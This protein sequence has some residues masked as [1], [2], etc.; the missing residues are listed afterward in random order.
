MVHQD[1]WASSLW[2]TLYRLIETN[3]DSISISSSGFDHGLSDLLRYRS[4]NRVEMAQ[5]PEVFC[6][7]GS[8]FE[9]IFPL[10]VDWAGFESLFWV[11]LM[12]VRDVG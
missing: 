8:H 10:D 9:N 3:G 12:V 4:R 1:E 11:R 7:A 6:T 2:R 5:F